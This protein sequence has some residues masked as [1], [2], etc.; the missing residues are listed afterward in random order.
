ML[1]GRRTKKT[2]R[3]QGK[4]LR[5]NYPLRNQKLYSLFDRPVPLLVPKLL[6]Y[7][8]LKQV[9]GIEHLT[10]RK[11]V[12]NGGEHHPCDGDNG[13]LLATAFGNTLV[14]YPVVSGILSFHSGVSRLHES[15][16]EINT[17]P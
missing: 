4:V 8:D 2:L 16:F 11:H 3:R 12:E 7:V 5:K 14:F 15:G 17:S 9:G 10:G 13:P 1:E 6:G